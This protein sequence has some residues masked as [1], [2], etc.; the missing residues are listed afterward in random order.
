[1]N[2][3]FSN[4]YLLF[5]DHIMTQVPEIRWIDL[6]HGQLEAYE[7]RP[8]VS[9]PCVLIDFNQTTYDQGQGGRQIAN[10]TFTLRLALDSFSTSA[11]TAPQ[12]T[13][14]KA[15]DI[16]E[17]EQ[18]LYEAI[19]G[20]NAD[21]LIDDCN[22]ISSVTERREGDTFRVRVNTF[23]TM[24]FDT[25]SVFQY[26]KAKRPDLYLMLNVGQTIEQSQE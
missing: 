23:T 12:A 25:S 26:I 3:L 22:R 20:Y 1:M 15:L 5:Q 14:E 2:S 10:L 16:F 11:S 6:D 7:V 19:Q 9:F 24:T 13:K 4:L 8:A 21:G 18:K 17:L